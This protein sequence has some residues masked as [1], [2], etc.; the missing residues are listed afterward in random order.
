MPPQYLEDLRAA[1]LHGAVECVELLP[2][3]EGHSAPEVNQLAG[4]P[5]G[6]GVID[7]D[8]RVP[9]SVNPVPVVYDDVLVLNVPVKDAAGV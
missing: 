7:D 8:P 6:A 1:I 9:D 3:L 4:E 2:G 5:G